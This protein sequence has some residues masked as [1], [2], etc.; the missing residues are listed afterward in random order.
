MPSF[1]TTSRQTSDFFGNSGP[2]Q[3]EINSIKD[4]K[5]FIDSTKSSDPVFRTYDA[6]KIGAIVLQT[7]C[8]NILNNLDLQRYNIGEEQRQRRLRY[9]L[10]DSFIY[11]F[12][13]DLPGRV[14]PNQTA[15]D[16]GY[17]DHYNKLWNTS[18]KDWRDEKFS[19]VDNQSQCKRAMGI[20]PATRVKQDL[21]NGS[22]KCYLCGK[23]MYIPN[24]PPE[25]ST[26]E[27]EHILSI[28]PALSHWWLVKHSN[29]TQDDINNLKYE[30]RWSCR[31]CN[32]V[33]S[34]YE[35]ILYDPITNRYIENNANIDAILD[36]IQLSTSYD[37]PGVRFHKGAPDF[38]L[39]L[40][41]DTNAWDVWKG[42]RKQVIGRKQVI[43]AILKPLLTK[44][45]QN[46]DECGDRDLYILFTK[47]KVLS[48][49]SNKSFIDAIIGDNVTKLP[50]TIA[51]K[52]QQA[53]EL[54]NQQIAA[55]QD[56]A[57]MRRKDMINSRAARAS[58]RRGRGIKLGGAYPFNLGR[59]PS[60]FPEPDAR[61]SHQIIEDIEEINWEHLTDEIIDKL[62]TTRLDELLQVPPFLSPDSYRWLV[63]YMNTDITEQL[64]FHL[65]EQYLYLFK[66]F[67]DNPGSQELYNVPFQI[68]LDNPGSQELYN[69]PFQISL[70]SNVLTGN[71]SKKRTSRKFTERK[72]KKDPVEALKNGMKFI[73][74]LKIFKRVNFNL[75]KNKINFSEMNPHWKNKL[76]WLLIEVR[77]TQESQKKLSDP[78]KRLRKELIDE[79]LDFKKSNIN[80]QG[81]I[82]SR[83][84]KKSKTKKKTKP[85]KKQNQK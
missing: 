53:K 19:K 31:C 29:H 2:L 25:I 40:N 61:P 1:F 35:M 22:Y 36:Q 38:L 62:N 12:C 44:I 69:V 15:A 51:E 78:W 52:R 10:S 42:N 71:K 79:A 64:M 23:S 49:L 66:I 70:Q 4:F 8:V 77:K 67:L 41:I 54:R 33:K 47:F 6:N 34:N 39:G 16:G 80:A 11:N 46:L 3:Q 14:N 5:E 57:A 28:L 17:T 76:K 30:Y 84:K 21:M 26:M 81:L 43:R 20:H 27:C 32:Q 37:C 50:L 9:F 63:D 82:K 59:I 58:R 72:I 75:Q 45:N 48:A 7:Y 18:F 68:S 13:K 65:Y 60:Q 73:K 24:R 85:K 56:A 55:D 83:S 74:T